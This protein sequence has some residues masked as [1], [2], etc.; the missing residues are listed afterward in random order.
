M[1]DDLTP[2]AIARAVAA[3][4]PGRAVLAVRDRGEWVRRI[5]IERRVRSPSRRNG[6][7][8]VRPYRTPARP[9]RLAR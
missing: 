7:A 1:T 4:L 3:H 9:D 2:Q 6:A 5:F 8:S